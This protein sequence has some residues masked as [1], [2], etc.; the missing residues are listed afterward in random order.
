[1]LEWDEHKRAANIEK[2]GLD[3]TRAELLFDGRPSIDI[4]CSFRAEP[5]LLTIGVIDGVFVTLVWTWRGRHRRAISFR[6]ARH[7]ERQA[8][9]QLLD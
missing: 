2:H 5:R 8:H 4:P 1:M 3:F 7:G 6:R 9:R